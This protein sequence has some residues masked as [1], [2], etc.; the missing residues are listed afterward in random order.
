MGLLS[1][2]AIV[3]SLLLL[4][5]ATSR[6]VV[7]T[8][9]EDLDLDWGINHTYA[10]ELWKEKWY[11]AGWEP[12]VLTRQ[13]AEQ[14]PFWKDELS[15]NHWPHV[16]LHKWMTMADRGGYM[17][18]YDVYPLAP[19]P[20]TIELSNDDALLVHQTLAPT[21]VSG[22]A[23]AWRVMTQSL[24][25]HFKVSKGF[26]TDTLALHDLR[27]HVQERRDFVTFEPGDPNCDRKKN[28]WLVHIGPLSFP[29]LLPNERFVKARAWMNRWRDVCIQSE[30]ASAATLVSTST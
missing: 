22:S 4:Y 9:Y 29:Y 28:R 8:Y 17:C 21:M 18:D 6:P 5:Q 27:S 1:R 19:P 26:W 10:L 11:K 2:V 15:G 25:E 12:I 16:L 24:I 3:W 30:N 20:T 13:N 14:S 7:H 23:M